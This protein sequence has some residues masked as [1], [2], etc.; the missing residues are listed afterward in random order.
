MKM[1]GGEHFAWRIVSQSENVVD[2]R[3][4]C[5]GIYNGKKEQRKN[6]KRGQA[7]KM[8]Y[9]HITEGRFI[10]RPNRFIAHVEING[11][12]ETV[13]VKNTGRCRELL[14]PGTQVFLERSSNPARKTAYD[15]ICVN[16][17]GRGL[18]NMD[19]Q[20]PN[21]AAL[22]WVKAGH[23]FPEKVQVTPE[24]TYGNSRFDLYVCSEKRKAFIEVKGVTLESDNIARFPDAP[25]ERG[26]KHLKEL[27]HCMQEG[28]EAYLLLVIQMKGVDRFEPNWETHREFG[29][30][31][32]EAKKAGVHI[33]AYDCL[34]EPDRM[35]IQDP[36]PVCLASDWK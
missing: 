7:E 10:D 8:K 27:I 24:K 21:K 36:V 6:R 4:T 22:E 15:L 33:L 5:Y 14:V 25:T 31:L 11:Q 12:V 23:L 20:I 18:I 16:K 34:V 30:T 9:E 3:K 13:H 2:T 19:S 26:V 35:E 28:Y 17:K 32:Q 1:W 29:E